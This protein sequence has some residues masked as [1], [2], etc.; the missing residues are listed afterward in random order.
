VQTNVAEFSS[1]WAIQD[2]ETARVPQHQ[3]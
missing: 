1:V 3:T 2:S